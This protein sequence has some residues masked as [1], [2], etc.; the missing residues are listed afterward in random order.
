MNVSLDWLRTWL[1][2]DH[3]KGLDAQAISDILTATGL[4]VEGVEE[5]PAVPGGL[6]GMVVGNVLTCEQHPNA[7]RLRVTT[8]D[9]GGDA[10]LNIVCGA[11][12]V[13]AGQK[14]IVATVGAVC[15]PTEGEPFKIKKGKIRGEVSEGMI[16]AEDEL[17]LGKGHDGILVLD[18]TAEIGAGA[19]AALGVESDHRIEIGLTPNRTDAMGHIGVARDLRAALLWNGGT[20]TGQGVPALAASA[21][22]ALSEGKGPISLEVEDADGAPRYMGITL[23]NV[24]VGPSPEWLQ[25]RLRA[26]GLEPKNNVVDVTNYVLHDL[27]QPLHAFDADRIAGDQV[28]V[29]KATE[30]EAFTAL[31]GKEMTLTAADLVIADAEK[32]MCLAGV[33]G[34]VHSSVHEGTTSVF[35]ESAWFEPVTIRKSA[36]RHTLSTDASFRFERG[37]DPE[38]T[39]SGMEKAVSLLA[40]CAGATVDGGLQVFSGDWPQAACVELSWETL[41]TMIGVPLDRQRVKGILASLDIGIVSEDKGALSLSVPAY[42]RDVTRPA[43]VVEE[44]LRIHGYDHIPLPGRMTISLSPKPH[45]DPE[46]LRN[47]LAR[48]LVGRGFHEVMHNSLV[49]SEHL[50]L[51]EDQSLDPE[52]AVILLN[53]LS[54]E[55]DAMRQSLLFQGLETVA[56]NKNHQRPDLSLFEFGKVYAQDGQGGHVES[57]QLGLTVSGLTAPES[58]RKLDQDGMSSLKGAVEALLTQ[59]GVSGL[60][61][62]PLPGGDL[63]KEGLEWKGPKGFSV[64]AGLVH[65]ALCRKFG[66]DVDVFH[67]DL[68]FGGLVSWSGKGKIKAR[69]LARFPS[70]RR[71]LSLQ[72]PSGVTYAGIEGVVRQT[73]GKLLR[74]VNLFDV[75]HDEK[76]E[77]TSYAISVQL[78]DAEKTLSEKA[79]DKTMERICGQLDQRLGVTLR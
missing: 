14:V 45:P 68:P 22:P 35:L 71:D 58:W 15:H 64:R 57:E 7:D 31:D 21:S 3:Q 75:Y 1:P 65:P 12:N 29:R 25:Q 36:K 37:V 79:I 27:G 61:C 47:D 78:Q 10:P 4:E 44:V 48:T 66:L 34:G 23:R 40:E 26:I 30:G 56:R 18:A 67:A 53:P 46:Q 73:G 50:K 5:I 60:Q 42:R 11:P 28:R 51:T 70:V 41:D 76:T 19:A 6:K 16:C 33:F 20:G 59:C 32:P 74:D 63:F 49:P 24:Q 62:A 13:A 69:E 55:L 72:V 43:D 54:S 8:V 38:M 2:I 39:P 52:R 17:G 77:K 9:V